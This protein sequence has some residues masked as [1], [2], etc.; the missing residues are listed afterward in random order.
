VYIS[1]IESVSLYKTEVKT[2]DDQYCEN[3][4]ICI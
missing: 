3:H 4:F 2:V 1:D